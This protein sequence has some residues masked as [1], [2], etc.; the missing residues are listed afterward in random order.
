MVLPV[1]P[2][3]SHDYFIWKYS[4][5]VLKVSLEN[6]FFLEALLLEHLVTIRTSGPTKQ[7]QEEHFM[8]ELFSESIS[9]IPVSW[10]GW[11]HHHMFLCAWLIW[12]QK[13]QHMLLG[14]QVETL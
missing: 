11:N 8:A 13:H 1:D 4:V 3:I 5:G 10:R 2:N 9:H 12:G 7:E 14:K 6:I